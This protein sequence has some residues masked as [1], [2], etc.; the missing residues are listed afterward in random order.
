MARSPAHR[1]ALTVAALAAAGWAAVVA[2]LFQL[3]PGTAQRPPTRV[4]AVAA[5]GALAASVWHGALQVYDEVDRRAVGLAPDDRL[6]VSRAIVEEAARAELAPLLVLAVIH[7]ESR[8]DPRAVSPVGAVGLM[9]LMRPTFHA[10]AADG[11]VAPADPFDPVANVRAGVRYLHRLV[12]TFSSVELA[13]VAYNAGPARVRRH[14]ETGGVPAR[15]YGYPRDVLREAVRLWPAPVALAAVRAPARRPLAL[16]AAHARPAA[17]SPRPGG[18][19]LRD[20]PRSGSAFTRAALVAGAAVAAAAPVA[21]PWDRG[22][23]V[24]AAP[25][26]DACVPREVGLPMSRGR[27]RTWTLWAQPAARA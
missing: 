4:R 16:A 2:V 20:A 8:F 6:R 12:D 27:D 5:H 25:A 10:E 3:F 15:L 18:L 9:Q 19:A 13:L 7:V 1:E 23:P 26:P 14:L 11:A 24:R 21:P 22:G 17:T